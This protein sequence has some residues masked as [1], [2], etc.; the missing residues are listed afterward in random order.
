MPVK[1]SL[2]RDYTMFLRISLLTVLAVA[3]TQAKFINSEGPF[4]LKV[5]KDRLENNFYPSNS[6]DVD[7]KTINNLDGIL[8]GPLGIFPLGWGSMV[9]KNAKTWKQVGKHTA[10][11]AVYAAF[12]AA[13]HAARNGQGQRMQGARLEVEAVARLYFSGMFT[14]YFHSALYNYIDKGELPVWM[15]KSIAK[16]KAYRKAHPA[17][18]HP[19]AAA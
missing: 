16:A 7:K 10:A 15:Q 17:S 9:A 13:L 2:I 4:N 18:Q 1:L 12:F 14:T 5:D 6:C 11:A 3:S 8:T 19:D